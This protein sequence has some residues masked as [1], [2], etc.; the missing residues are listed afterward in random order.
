MAKNDSV[1]KTLMVAFVLCIVCSVV[2]STAAVV[3]RP[4]QAANEERDRKFNVLQVAEL[5]EPG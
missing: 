3:L 5:Y 1:K 4:M 2:V